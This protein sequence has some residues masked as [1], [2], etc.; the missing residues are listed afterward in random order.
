VHQIIEQDMRWQYD[1]CLY[2][3]LICSK[4]KS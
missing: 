4:P 1:S 2:Q 3:A